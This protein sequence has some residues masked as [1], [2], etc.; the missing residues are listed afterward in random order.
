M[1]E[2]PDRGGKRDFPEVAPQ[3]QDGERIL[4]RDKLTG[5]WGG[6]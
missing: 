6:F 4:A 5:G 3:K 1:I 2:K